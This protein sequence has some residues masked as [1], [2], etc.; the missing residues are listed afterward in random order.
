MIIC[1]CPIQSGDEEDYACV[2]GGVAAP[3]A[4]KGQKR[5]A[6]VK[7]RRVDISDDGL[8]S[9][10]GLCKKQD[11]VERA[12]GA[13]LAKRI[14]HETAEGISHAAQGCDGTSLSGFRYATT[15]HGCHR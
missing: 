1:I 14:R 2:V 11:R 4:C 5:K 10:G 8:V 7:S 15:P 12:E 13:A 6:A 3:V 9:I